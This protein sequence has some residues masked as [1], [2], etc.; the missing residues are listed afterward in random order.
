MTDD[1][2]NLAELRAI[3]ETERELGD[4]EFEHA[5]TL[6]LWQVLALVEAVEA[7]HDYYH[8]GDGNRL[9]E[10]LERFEWGTDA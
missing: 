3:V 4:P 10:A 2:I 1:R 5:S 8:M 7:A 9:D 6:Y